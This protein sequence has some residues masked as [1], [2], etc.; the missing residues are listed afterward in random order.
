[1]YM[2]MG[3][4]LLA[5]VILLSAYV[6][7][8]NASIIRDF[9][10]GDIYM[11]SALENPRGHKMELKALLEPNGTAIPEHEFKMTRENVKAIEEDGDKVVFLKPSTMLY[12]FTK[13]KTTDTGSGEVQD[14]PISQHSFREGVHNFTNAV[15]NFEDYSDGIYLLDVVANNDFAHEAIVII[16]GE[17]DDELIDRL[18]SNINKS[19]FIASEMFT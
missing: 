11:S 17:V 14:I 13:A 2:Y 5:T 12:N 19:E 1:M 15:I 16:G 4:A 10:T 3:I 18:L 9:E 8:V 7:T 6:T